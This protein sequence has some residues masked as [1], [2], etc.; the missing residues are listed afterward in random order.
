MAVAANKKAAPK[1]MAGSIEEIPL[2]DLLQLLS[3]S[4]KSGRAGRSIRTPTSASSSS[5]RGR[6]TSPTSRTSTASAPRKAIVRMLG[7]TQGGFELEPPDETAVLEEIEDSTEA[8]LMEGMRQ[9]DEY[10]VQLEK[11]PAFSAPIGVPRPLKAQA[12]RARP[13]GARRVPGRAPR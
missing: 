2:P 13:G 12:A 1:S 8:L 9:L 11:L 6:S 5:A 3:T 4:R 7:W 10:R